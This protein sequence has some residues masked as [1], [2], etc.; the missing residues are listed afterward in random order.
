MKHLPLTAKAFYLPAYSSGVRSSALS[1]P[2]PAGNGHDQGRTSSQSPAWQTEPRNYPAV[3]NVS[4]S[5]PDC[6]DSWLDTS[7]SCW[8]LD[9]HLF[10]EV[11]AVC[12]SIQTDD[13]LLWSGRLTPTARA[14]TV[15]KTGATARTST[16]TLIH[17]SIVAIYS[18][19]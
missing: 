8:P 9:K 10:A 14:A 12:S 15:R 16:K 5:I 19:T 18:L 7:S 1:G 13:P 6:A 3:L 11:F 2:R 4:K 17:S